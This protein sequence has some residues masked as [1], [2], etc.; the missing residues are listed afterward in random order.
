MLAVE[1]ANMDW[2]H[3]NLA[4][5]TSSSLQQPVSA[6]GPEHLAKICIRMRVDL[7]VVDKNQQKPSVLCHSPQEAIAQW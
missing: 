6:V 1:G 5:K 3:S 7:S 2:R 4:H